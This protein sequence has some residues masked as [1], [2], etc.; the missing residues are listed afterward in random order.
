M[1]IEINLDSPAIIKTNTDGPM[2][3]YSNFPQLEHYVKQ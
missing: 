1:F 2:Y 3:T